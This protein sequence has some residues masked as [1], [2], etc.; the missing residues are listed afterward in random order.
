MSNNNQLSFLDIVNLMS[1]CIT[2]MNLNENLS[3]GDKQDLQQDLSE[4]METI[5]KEV[6]GHLKE[7]DTK[8]DKILEVVSND[9]K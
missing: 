9:S 7:Q 8:I 5:L 4:K 3:Q 6:H 1:F 2:L